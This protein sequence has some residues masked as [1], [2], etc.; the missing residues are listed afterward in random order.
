MHSTFEMFWQLVI[1]GCN[2]CFD[3]HAWGWW[4]RRR[5]FERTVM[6]SLKCVQ[7]RF[8]LLF[9][10]IHAFSRAFCGLPKILVKVWHFEFHLNWNDSYW[11]DTVAIELIWLLLNCKMALKRN[12]K[13]KDFIFCRFGILNWISKRFQITFE[14]KLSPFL[15]IS[16]AQSHFER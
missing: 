6:H 8:Q 10:S 2:G 14:L 13:W 3:A 1:V 12:F 7:M 5:W 16:M 15:M 9:I 4:W 11:N